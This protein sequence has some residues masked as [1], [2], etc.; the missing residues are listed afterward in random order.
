MDG[1]SYNMDIIFIYIIY[2]SKA[3]GGLRLQGMMD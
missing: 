1:L 3:S 2:K